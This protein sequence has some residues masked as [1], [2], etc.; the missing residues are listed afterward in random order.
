MPAAEPRYA[1]AQVTEECR[2]AWRE[3]CEVHDVDRTVLAE[4]IGQ[5]MQDLSGDLPPLVRQWVSD[6]RELKNA[7]KRR[8]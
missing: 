5:W 8:G 7:R 2:D 1:I 4:V 3:F 6:A